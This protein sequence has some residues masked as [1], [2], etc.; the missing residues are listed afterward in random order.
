MD[1]GEVKYSRI[2]SALSATEGVNDFKDLQIGASSSGT[3]TYGT[4]N[5]TI[6]NSQLPSVSSD[7]LTLTS[8]TV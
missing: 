2:W 4:S 6:T 7:N 8:G 3:V 1:D 5:I